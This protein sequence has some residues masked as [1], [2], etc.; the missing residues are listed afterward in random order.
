[1][2]GVKAQLPLVSRAANTSTA[3][4]TIPIK[5]DNRLISPTEV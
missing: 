5:P 2:H 3:A 4:S 1:M